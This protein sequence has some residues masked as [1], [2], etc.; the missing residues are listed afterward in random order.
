MCICWEYKSEPAQSPQTM[1]G[2]TIT[3]KLIVESLLLYPQFLLIH[4]FFHVLNKTHNNTNTSACIHAVRVP[5][6]R[7]AVVV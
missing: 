3:T 6:E 4:H 2:S 1:S 7:W 5:E